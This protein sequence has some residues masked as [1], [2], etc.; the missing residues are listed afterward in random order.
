[1]PEIKALMWDLETVPSPEIINNPDHPLYPKFDEDEQVEKI[2]KGNVSKP[3][4]I[5]R[6]LEEARV[7]FRD[8]GWWK[9]FSVN[10]WLCAPVVFSAYSTVEQKEYCFTYCYDAGANAT[11]ILREAEANLLI[12]AWPVIERH[13]KEGI[14]II[15]YNSLSFDISV[16]IKRSCRRDIHVSPEMILALTK[17][18]DSNMDHLDLELILANKSPFSSTPEIKAMEWHMGLH[19]LKGKYAGMTGAD[20]FPHWVAGEMKTLTDYGMGDIWCMRDLCEVTWPWMIYPYT[21]QYQRERQ[22]KE[23]IAEMSGKTQ[24]LA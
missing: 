10:P 8:G 3:E 2:K 19:G 20:V 4:T 5:A 12:E 1:M 22:R 14:P 23:F 16:M 17:R 21:R 11:N 9:P 15:G 18:W 24:A 7:A 6:K 13:Y